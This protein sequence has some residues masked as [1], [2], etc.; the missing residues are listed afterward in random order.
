MSD[1]DGVVLSDGD[2]V[3]FTGTHEGFLKYGVVRSLRIFNLHSKRTANINMCGTNIL[4]IPA[5][6]VPQKYKDSVR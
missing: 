1:R 3:I 5:S 4:R 6:I 2:F